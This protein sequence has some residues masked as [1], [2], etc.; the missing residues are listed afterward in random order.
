MTT[1]YLIIMKSNSNM[2]IR[3][4]LVDDHKIILDSLSLLFDLTEGIHVVGTLNDSRHVIDFLEEHEVDVLVTDLTMPYKDGIQLSFE[5]KQHF[6]EMKILML[7][8]NDAPDRIQDAY[9]AGISGYVMKKAGR[10]ELEKAIAT[11]ASGQMHFSQEV[12]RSI[13][14]TAPED[15]QKQVLAKLTKRELE[16]I[17][18][19][20]AEKSSAEIANDLFIS[21]GTVETHRHNIFKK[22]GVKNAIGV[23]KFALKYDL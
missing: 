7:T 11:V 21:V 18:L 22:L 16:I 17:R 19:M 1:I 10:E 6:P 5:V 8:V 13:L 14:T 12:M 4:L 20:V 23:V 15:N 3:I 2:P 9:K